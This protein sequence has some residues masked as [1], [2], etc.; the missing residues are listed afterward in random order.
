MTE[1]SQKFEIK[2]VAFAFAASGLRVSLEEDGAL[3]FGN[4]DFIAIDRAETK[5]LRDLITALLEAT[6]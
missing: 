1:A 3:R 2:L 5:E 4:E 6:A